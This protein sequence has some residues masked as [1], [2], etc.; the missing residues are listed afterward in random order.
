MHYTQDDFQWYPQF[1]VDMIFDCCGTGKQKAVHSG[2]NKKARLV[3]GKHKASL[4]PL[5][6]RQ[7]NK[8]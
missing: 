3:S 5:S 6:Q 1:Y 2:N 4:S 8:T 7:F